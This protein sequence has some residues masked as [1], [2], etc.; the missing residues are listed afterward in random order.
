MT[1]RS[2]VVGVVV[3]DLMVSYFA[4][5]AKVIAGEI[6][7]AGYDIFLSNSEENPAAEAQEVERLLGRQVDGLIIA[8]S[9]PAKEKAPFVELAARG[10]PFVLIDRRIEGLRASFV[11]TN[12]QRA[13]EMATGHLVQVGCR[14]I[15]HLRGRRPA[16]GAVGWPDIAAP[17]P[18]GRS[19]WNRA[20]PA[21]KAATRP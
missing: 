7:E 14:R 9:F 12:D 13:G 1:N 8:T 3:P 16:P 5:V 11:G 6:R 2:Y 20:R 19:G 18:E 21:W 10:V 4:E 15:A 17:W